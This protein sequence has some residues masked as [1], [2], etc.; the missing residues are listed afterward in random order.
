MKSPDIENLLDTLGK[1]GK[2]QSI[3]FVFLCINLWVV[4]TNHMASVFFTAKTDYSCKL[5]R[6]ASSNVLKRGEGRTD[7]CYV[8]INNSSEK[9]TSWNYNLPEGETTI[10]SEV[11]NIWY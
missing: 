9:C 5:D 7:N 2:L 3:S 4:M 6:N 10:I 8:V 11:F 1:P